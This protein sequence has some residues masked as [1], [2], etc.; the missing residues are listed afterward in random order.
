[1]FAARYG[2][3]LSNS[4]LLTIDRQ[5]LACSIQSDHFYWQTFLGYF[6]K[7]PILVL[8]S[9]LRYFLLLVSSIIVFKLIHVFQFV[10]FFWDTSSFSQR[11]LFWLLHISPSLLFLE[12]LCY[13]FLEITWSRWCFGVKAASSE[14]RL[15]FLEDDEFCHMWDVL[16]TYC[17]ILTWLWSSRSL[18][19]KSVLKWAMN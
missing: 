1:M 12:G 14:V 11:Y 15:E 17:P 10:R 18:V 6:H 5:R 7:E 3:R 8:S 19:R 4:N 13:V 2:A 16:K 9:C